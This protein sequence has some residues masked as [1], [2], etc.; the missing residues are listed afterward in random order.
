MFDAPGRYVVADDDE[1]RWLVGEQTAVKGPA[2]P[3]HPRPRAGSPRCSND[4][5][6][7]LGEDAIEMVTEDPV[8]R[9]RSPRPTTEDL[10]ATAA[11][12]R[13][14]GDADWIATERPTPGRAE[15][16]RAGRAGQRGRR[17]AADE[18]EEEPARG[19]RPRRRAGASVPSWDEIMFGGQA[20]V[21]RL[22]DREITVQ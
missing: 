9:G 19:A 22:L 11:A 20:G 3:H 8:P 7:P 18:P 10:S 1:A 16:S 17:A 21:S 5:E 14:T 6:L 4:D 12:V 15:P 13:A 2:A